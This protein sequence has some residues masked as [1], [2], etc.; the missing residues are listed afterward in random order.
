MSELGKS[1]HVWSDMVFNIQ[2]LHKTVL[3]TSTKT[4]VVSSI[5]NDILFPMAELEIL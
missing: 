2:E 5:I 4:K 1:M 3:Q